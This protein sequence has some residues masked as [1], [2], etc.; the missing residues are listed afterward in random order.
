MS[1]EYEIEA[2]VDQVYA[3]L[4][5]PDYLSER[6]L[7]IGELS[8]EIEV[9]EGDAET[10]VIMKRTVVRDLPG[11]LAKIFSPEQEFEL[12]ETWRDTEQGLQASYILSFLSQPVTVYADISLTPTDDGCIYEI[13]HR[14]KAKIPLI[15]GRVEKYVLGQIIEGCDDELVYLAEAL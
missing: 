5:D 11:W 15:G 1:I 2:G 13:E 6:S 8:V 3:L 14:C 10:T 9:Q 4:T 7:A 12:V